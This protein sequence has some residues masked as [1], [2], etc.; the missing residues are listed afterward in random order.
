[1]S[2]AERYLGELMCALEAPGFDA[3]RVERACRELAVSLS[4]LTGEEPRVELGRILVLHAA[5]RELAER[6]QAETRR[7]LEAVARTRAR[8]SSLTRPQD[9]RGAVDLDA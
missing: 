2:D 5:L 6:R 9:A 8:C 1:M 3:E 7:S 4:Q